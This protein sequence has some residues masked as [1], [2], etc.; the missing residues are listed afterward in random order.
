MRCNNSGRGQNRILLHISFFELGWVYHMAV[1][2]WNDDTIRFPIVQFWRICAYLYEKHVLGSTWFQLT[3][4]CLSR[5]VW[6]Y[7]NCTSLYWHLSSGF[8]YI[9]T[10]HLDKAKN[11]GDCIQGRRP[12]KANPGKRYVVRLY[13][14]CFQIFIPLRV[15]LPERWNLHCFFFFRSGIFLESRGK[16]LEFVPGL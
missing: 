8:I 4:F 2:V 14:F 1:N 13:S 11:K 6:L 10:K 5:P 16:A 12:L 3:C 15:V 9:F 7:R